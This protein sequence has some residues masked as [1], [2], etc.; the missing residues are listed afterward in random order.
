LAQIR[1]RS[2]HGDP[3]DLPDTQTLLAALEANLG[4]C[5]SWPVQGKQLNLTRARERGETHIRW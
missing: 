1:E 3:V 5:E 4:L 2:A